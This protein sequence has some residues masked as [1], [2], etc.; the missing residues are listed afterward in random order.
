M[1]TLTLRDLQYRRRQFAVAVVGAALVFCLALV[2]T[3]V[4]AGFGTEADRTVEAVGADVWFVPAGV[5]G[6]FTSLSTLPAELAEEAARDGGVRRADAIV[7]LPH[8]LRH[9]GEALSI[10][11]FG[12]RA[13]GLG[14]PRPVAGRAARGP[15]EAVVDDALGISLGDRFTIADR[16][17]RVVGRVR[18]RSYLGGIPVVFLA[19]EEAQA[20]AF[21]GRSLASA[22]AVAG[23]PGQP[24]PG[25]SAL[26]NAT[27]RD[28]LVRPLEG[29]MSAID[30]LRLLMWI[31][32]AV[33]IGAVT[34][35]SALE[36]VR[37]FAV[38]QA[39]G[40][41]PRTLA[42]SL[43]LQ[44][45]VASLLAAAIGAG[46]AAALQPVFPLP[47]TISAQAYV[48]LF[49][50]AALVGLVASL[51]ALRRATAVDPALAFGA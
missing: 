9:D 32:A 40:A 7:T 2:L 31:V 33:I 41:P 16:A 34:Y 29:A 37:D 47:V 44:A 18:D 10:N 38:L 14:S 1:L 39:I 22:I 3:G 26:S 12:H 24:P 6:P 21:D 35:L 49:V 13:G 50:I 51:A 5:T 25:V 19:L 17:L 15:G 20:L 45:V 36:R 30:T 46:V 28:D 43:S 48:G 27:V 8:T 11:V 23:A 4:R 42:A